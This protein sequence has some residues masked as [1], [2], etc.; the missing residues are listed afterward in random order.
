MI[1]QNQVRCLKCGDEPYSAHV[2]DFKYCKCGAIAVDG[3]MD[4]LRRVG[5]MS[6]YKDLSY[7]MDDKII[8]ECVEEVDRMIKSKRNG[9]GITLG[10]FRIL[11]KHQRLI[12]DRG[13][14]L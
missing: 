10:V 12:T 9:L 11:H 14:G 6:A 7:S 4:Y 3:G 5:D 13:K 1:C 8:G 2:H